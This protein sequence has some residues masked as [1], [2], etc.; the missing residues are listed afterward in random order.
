MKSARRYRAL[1]EHYRLASRATKNKLARHQLEALEH[2]YRVLAQSAAVL[3]RSVK[4]T[5]KLER[6]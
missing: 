2:S 6:K 3:E 5:K 4:V 1:A